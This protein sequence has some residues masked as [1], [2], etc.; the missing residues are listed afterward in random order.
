MQDRAAEA[1]DGA[2]IGTIQREDV[3]KVVESLT[4]ILGSL[5]FMEIRL[6]SHWRSLWVK[7]WDP[8]PAKIWDEG[9][10][11]NWNDIINLLP[12]SSLKSMRIVSYLPQNEPYS[13]EGVAKTLLD[14]GSDGATFL[15]R[16][17][18]KD[19]RI[20]KARV[21]QFDYK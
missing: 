14:F 10:P 6:L 9:P 20:E 16:S 11:S 1:V 19:L 13:S 18:L 15:R 5:D 21:A 8:T 2:S 4:S 3:M 17:E 12:S 7:P